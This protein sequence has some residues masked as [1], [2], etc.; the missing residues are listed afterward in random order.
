MILCQSNVSVTD[1]D[2]SFSFCCTQTQYDDIVSAYLHYKKVY[3]EYLHDVSVAFVIK[4]ELFNKVPNR[5]SCA[6][7]EMTDEEK[8]LHAELT[9]TPKVENH[10][11]PPKPNGKTTEE[12]EKWNRHRKSVQ[13]LLSVVPQNRWTK[14]F[15]PKFFL[16]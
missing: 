11:S 5:K 2:K 1:R 4:N 9:K 15:I 8:R 12:Q 7:E 14:Q 13:Q 16:R 6:M 3:Y 10:D